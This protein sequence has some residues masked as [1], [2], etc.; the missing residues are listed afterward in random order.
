V[1]ADPNAGEGEGRG[2]AN[3]RGAREA[4]G[5]GVTMFRK[6]RPY[7]HRTKE[8][9]QYQRAVP[10]GGQLLCQSTE[11]KNPALTGVGSPTVAG[12]LSEPEEEGVKAESTNP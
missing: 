6:V 3:T 11:T 2:L 10:P 9:V 5:N 7:Q 8:K 4:D 1:P 12:C